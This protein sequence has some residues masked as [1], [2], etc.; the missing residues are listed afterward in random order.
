MKKFAAFILAGY[1]QAVLC[2]AGLAWLAMY[3]PVAAMFS[4]SALALTALKWGPQRA[5]IVL[6]LSTAALFGFSF[7]VTSLDLA[8][9]SYAGVFLFSLL[10][11]L[12][13]LAIARLLQIT[14][15]SNTLNVLVGVGL[16]VVAS[17]S[18]LVPESA[19][20]W[21]RFFNWILAGSLQ[22][23]EADTPEFRGNYQAFLN[24]MTG[25][26]M[27]AMILMWVLSLLL[28]RWW[29]G[30]VDSGGFRAEFIA[31]KLG[32]GTAIAGL[33]IFSVMTFSEW[34]LMREML[35]VMMVA[36][37]LQGIAT[38]HCLLCA[39]NNPGGWLLAFYVTLA[40]SPMVPQI[41][42]LLSMLGALENLIELRTRVKSGL[43]NK[44]E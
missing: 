7:L 24:I 31:L 26:A 23:K 35:L 4:S 41:P 30:L 21:D 15:L 42:G 20:L 29:Q 28:A 34:S 19:D 11:W 1:G 8:T 2:I 32:K 3:V 22:Q 27:A 38:V 43:R 40:L 44:Q 9:V 6:V 10:Q 12:P 37:L 16:V 18:L 33:I 36:F 14:S 13:V 25:V 39:L 17:V 5:I